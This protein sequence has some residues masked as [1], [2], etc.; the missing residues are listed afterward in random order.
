MKN[1]TGLRV[2][3]GASVDVINTM[4]EER[5]VIQFIEHPLFVADGNLF[6]DIS[7]LILEKP[8][9]ISE[10][11]NYL[12]LPQPNMFY[13]GD[14][15]VS[16]GWSRHGEFIVYRSSARVFIFFFHFRTVKSEQDRTALHRTRPMP[17]HA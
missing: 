1:K 10:T 6:Y 9:P 4:N 15:C 8:Y 5:R 17:T 11:L 12:C 13:T 7:I 3:A 2:L 16:S 14:K